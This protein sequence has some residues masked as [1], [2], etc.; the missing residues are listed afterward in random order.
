VFVRPDPHPEGRTRGN[1]INVTPGRVGDNERYTAAL[2]AGN[3][4]YMTLLEKDFA[5]AGWIA[6]EV[7][8][9]MK[10]SDDFYASEGAQVRTEKLC[11]G[12]IVLLGDAGYA[13]QGIGTSNA[14]L[15]GYVLAGELM[16]NQWN[17]E[18]ALE[19]YQELILPF[20]KAAQDAIP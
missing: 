15:G 10:E 5:D 19:K 6:P 1:L 9:A 12:R 2:S 3:E 16:S 4:A 14:I 8:T 7:L 17:V 11:D 18:A 20:V 13:T